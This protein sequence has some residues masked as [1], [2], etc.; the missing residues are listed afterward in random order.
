MP[1][2]YEAIRTE[3]LH[4]YGVDVGNYGGLLVDIYSDRTQFLFELLQNAQDAHATRVRFDLH[5][6]R[7]EVRHNGRQFTEADV[8]G[9]CGIKRSTKADDPD[10]IGRFGIGF[11][12]VYAYTSRPTV[13]CGDEHF[14]VKDYVYPHPADPVEPGAEWSTLQILPFDRSDMT[15]KAAVDEI[16]RRLRRL[17]GRTILFLRNLTE[18]EWSIPNGRSYRIRRETR[19]ER[20]ARRVSLLT[21]VA[22]QSQE[23]WL[24]FDRPVHLADGV[25]PGAIEVA[26]ALTLD[27][28][29]AELIT[30][31][32]DTELVAFF[33]TSRE[34]H[35][36][37]LIQ[38]PF[39]PTASRDNVRDDHPLNRRLATEAAALTIDALEAI[40]EMGLL[41]AGALEAL[42][43]DSATFPRGNLLRPLYDSVRDALTNR[44]FL[45]TADGRYLAAT[46]VRLARGRGLRELLSP[47][48]L[49]ELLEFDGEVAWL[50]A[51]ISAD[52]T[53][54]LHRYL[55][56][57]RLFPWS[58]EPEVP[59]LVPGMELDPDAVFRRI[60]SSFL[61]RQPADW[62]ISFYRWLAG[63]PALVKTLGSKEIVRRS[64]GKH[65]SAFAGER[66]QVWLPPDG[67]TSYPVVDRVVAADPG[68]LDFLCTVG[69]TEPDAADEVVT[70]IL[71]RYHPDGEKPNPDEHTSNLDRIAAALIGATGTKLTALTEELIK[72]PFLLTYNPTNHNHYWRLP[73]QSY[74]P[75]DQ[76]EIF[77]EGSEDVFFLTDE[78]L[79]HIDLWRG[80]GVKS[81][82]EIL[83]RQP[84]RWTGYVTVRDR[85]SS[86]ERGRHRF[87]PD[88][89]IVGL[90]HALG[91][92]TLE[93][94]LLVWNLISSLDT[95]IRGEVETCTRSNYSG[96]Q[97]KTVNSPVAKL[98]AKHHWLLDLDG[99]WR[100]P[101]EITLDD[102]DSTYPRDDDLA[103]QLEMRSKV[104][105]EVADLLEIDSD[106]LDLLRR[107]PALVQRM[108]VEAREVE[109]GAGV[110]ESRDVDTNDD[111][112]D[113]DSETIDVPDA[114]FE[115]FNRQG[116]AEVDEFVG[117]GAA[118][119]PARR[120]E[121]SAQVLSRSKEAEPS[122]RA[123]FTFLSRKV[124]EPR[125]PAV[126]AY[127]LQTYGGRCQ[128]CQATFPRR[129]GEPFFEAR[130]IVSRVAR[131][132]L[133]TPGNS[134]CLCPTCLA[135]TLHGSSKAVD[136]LHELRELAED[137]INLPDGGTVSVELC[138]EPVSLRFAQRHLIDLGALLAAESVDP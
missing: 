64:D 108:M 44:P 12:S 72:T 76:L 41:K 10:Q 134:L 128:I 45:P 77:M 22:S 15:P 40:K 43:L 24:V 60:D 90:E 106:D 94:S 25:D 37:F 96:S 54:T 9:I 127:L 68:A 58:A 79:G 95:P 23:E 14:Q 1:S 138:G 35:V 112:G 67:E 129:D 63:Q 21:G 29:G 132:W 69:L 62:I 38:G 42:P 84:D 36:G 71:P 53:Q 98:L 49:G 110:N 83:R 92:P 52:R 130:Y 39:V 124:W 4:R 121:R 75:S 123:R 101:E 70:T 57:H 18:L 109:R 133:D 5:S 136:I 99:N 27:N 114:I 125:D 88:L 2:D 51:D 115:A 111:E 104:A 117:D 19:T 87:D 20:A 102:L 31:A 97:I 66:P 46:Q 135:K 16:S 32:K 103:R 8:T 28:R 113:S 80:L 89:R 7:L 11:K 119:N 26:F 61:A 13:H 6:D 126:R 120:Q 34:T 30:P 78:S 65:V 59:P 73:P 116:E 56:G 50:T 82:I 93:R 48:Q 3:H 33:P 118:A 81:G 47:E 137:V 74:E 100:M 105:R 91:N 86:H 85:H 122:R 55:V 131:R 17:S 107:H